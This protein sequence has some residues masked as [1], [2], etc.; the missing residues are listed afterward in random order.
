MPQVESPLKTVAVEWTGT[1]SMWGP[2]QTNTCNASSQNHDS[3]SKKKTGPSNSVKNVST[4]HKCLADS[5]RAPQPNIVTDTEEI[6]PHHQDKSSMSRT[7]GDLRSPEFWGPPSVPRKPVLSQHTKA[8][9][10]S[11]QKFWFNLIQKC[12]IYLQLCLSHAA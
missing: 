3:Y 6:Q 2:N 10:R 11:A 1:K 8:P 5:G 12:K 9:F 4:Q 7:I